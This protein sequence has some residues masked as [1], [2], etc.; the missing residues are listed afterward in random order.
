MVCRRISSGASAVGPV[1]H[2]RVQ[3]QPQHDAS[4]IAGGQPL[5]QGPVDGVDQFGEVGTVAAG[6]SA[7]C[8]R[9]GGGKARGE[10]VAHGVDDRRV[11]AAAVQGVVEPVPAEVVGGFE[12]GRGDDP[13]GGQRPLGEK[14]RSSS[15]GRDIV[16]VRVRRA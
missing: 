12:D 1:Q 7:G 6:V 8:Q 11:Q 4:G 13:A 16:W 10:V 15:E 14:A 5:G 9:Q 3:L 2:T